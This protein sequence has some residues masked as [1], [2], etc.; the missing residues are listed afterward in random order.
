MQSRVQEWLTALN[1]DTTLEGA[2]PADEALLAFLV[3]AALSD[4]DIAPGQFDSLRRVMPGE[5]D[6]AILARISDESKHPMSFEGLMMAVPDEADRLC[7]ERLATSMM[8]S[9]DYIVAAESAFLR[10]LAEAL[11]AQE[12]PL[13]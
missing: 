6:H 13:H 8:T 3:H 10:Q 5:S 7:L 9:D 1:T 12:Q 4:R 11:Q 2:H